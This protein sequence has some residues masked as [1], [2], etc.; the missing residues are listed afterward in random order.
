M[1][2]YSQ[3]LSQ[4]TDFLPRRSRNP[5]SQKK[6][7]RVEESTTPSGVERVEPTFRFNVMLPLRKSRSEFLHDPCARPQTVVSL[8]P[9]RVAVPGGYRERLAGPGGYQG[10]GGI[11]EPTAFKHMCFISKSV[12][13]E[14]F[15]CTGE[16]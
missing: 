16:A 8:T 4:S 2:P 3:H 14:C 1:D 10:V 6:S 11:W 5:S 7:E 13:T 15:A 12:A 9:R